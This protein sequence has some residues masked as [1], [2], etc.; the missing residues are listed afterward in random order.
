MQAKF[1]SPLAASELMGVSK[2]GV[3]K[4]INSGRLKA[5]KS[6]RIS[7]SGNKVSTFL[8]N[9]SDLPEEARLRYALMRDKT[10]NGDFD[11]GGYKA[12]FGEK[13]VS[14]LMERLDAVREMKLYKESGARDVCKKRAEI[15]A[16]IGVSPT[17]LSQLEKAYAEQG[18]SGM[19]SE[20][21]RAD[22]GAPRQLCRMAQDVVH[23]EACL[24]SRPKNRAIYERL[25]DTA[26]RLKENACAA[27]PY[28][29]ASLYRAMLRQAGQITENDVCDREDREGM[30][31]PEHRCTVD[32]YINSIPES[33][34][35]MGRHGARYWEAKYMPKVLREKPEKVNEVWFGDHHVFD[36]FVEGPDGRPVRPWLTAWMDAASG[37]MVG[38]VLSLNPNS[39][40]IVEAL[41]RA[42]GHTAGSPFW[43]APLMI[44]IDNGKDYRCRRIE[45]NGLR[46]YSVGQLNV[47]F[48]EQNALLKTLGIG[49]THAIPYRAWSKT[50]ERAFGTIERRW[51]QGILPGWC[52]NASETRPESLNEDVRQKRLLSYEDFAAYVFNKLLPE[53]HA[54]RGE[55]ESSPMEIYMASEKA[56]GDEVPSWAVLSSVKSNRTERR[57]GTTGIRFAKR[58]FNHPDLAEYIGKMVTVAYD[59]EDSATVSIYD[60]TQFICEAADAERFALVNEDEERLAGHMKRQKDAKKRDRAAITLPRTRV[61]MLNDMVMELED[62]E[63][64]ATLTSYI[65]ERAARDREAAQK[66]VAAF[67]SRKTAEARKAET[68]IRDRLMAKGAELLQQAAEG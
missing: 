16:K 44:Y 52:G 35:A 68:R 25:K 49:V 33:V 9:L 22:K 6:E 61:K 66:T 21:K 60:G 3:I 28:N 53:Y 18:I 39:D 8:I 54:F 14:E 59:R 64:P 12:R 65:H 43:G 17:R 1:I 47:S 56:R 2:Q 5:Q 24:S 10:D 36:V 58:V 13:G 50:I 27:C 15:A 63:T 40:T 19:A 7:A 11:L 38:A 41:T 34:R 4:S 20:T 57:V 55:Q 23:S 37:C 26:E 48:T 51:V 67:Q 45:G 30:V 46:D 29:P 32:R 42:I 62:V 31:V